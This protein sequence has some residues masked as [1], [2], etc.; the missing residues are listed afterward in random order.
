MVQQEG[1]LAVVT[2]GGSG[3]GRA[4]AHLLVGGGWQV[5]IGDR[6]EDGMK[7]TVRTCPT[8]NSSDRMSTHRVDVASEADFLRFRDEVSR[9]HKKDCIQLLINNAGILG[10]N[11]FIAGDRAEWEHVFG[12]NWGGVYLGTRTFL[13]LLLAADAGH[14]VNISSVCGFWASVGPDAVSSAYSTAK[15]AIKG[16]T[17]SLIWDLR[18][19]A[20][21][22][23]CSV[24]MPGHIG[25]AIL[26]NSHGTGAD[27]MERDSSFRSTA[28][29]NADEA[30]RIIMQG[31]EQKRWRI[32]VGNDAVDLD[33]RVRADPENA[34]ER[35]FFQAW[36]GDNPYPGMIR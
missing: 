22:V 34:Y 18:M 6:D 10:G 8:P 1:K 35:S 3:I 30:A 33:A 16:F 36:T 23:G 25:T 20:P 31:V 12:V 14:I 13:P 11:T 15:F 26:R 4:L 21:H 24:V 2:G 5:A 28:P 19:H 9:H 29:T 32:L 17:E 27:I 7:D